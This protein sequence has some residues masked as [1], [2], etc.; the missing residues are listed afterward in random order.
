MLAICS[1]NEEKTISEVFAKQSEMILHFDDFVTWRINWI[2]K[3][4]N[5]FDIVNELNIGLD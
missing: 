5:I 3:A 2:D 4:K 1:K